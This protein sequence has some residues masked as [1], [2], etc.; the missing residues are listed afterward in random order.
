[1]NKHLRLAIFSFVVFGSIVSSAFAQA[2]Q[3][4]LSGYIS[5]TDGGRIVNARIMARNQAG[6]EQFSVQS[7]VAGN[8]SVDNL[9]AGKYRVTVEAEGFSSVSRDVVVNG[10]ANQSLDIV[11]SV[12]NISESVTVTATR[13]EL[14]TMET[15]VPVSIVGREDLER[16]NP[17]SIGDIFRNLPGTSTVNEGSFQV[18]PRI[19]GLDSNRVLI[20]VDGERLNNA[21]TS[22]ANSGVEIGLVEV[23]QIQTLEVARGAGSVL[24]GT[25]AL[26]GTVNIITKDTP[27]RNEDGFRFGT[28]FNGFASSNED[29]R[30]GSF[31]VNGS[32]RL[33]AFRVSQSLE[34]FGNYSS[35]D[36]PFIADPEVLNSQSHAGNTQ[37]TARFF[38]DDQ[39]TLK[40]AYDRRR[41]SDI[42]SPTL[43]GVFN[44]FFPFSNREK[45]STR[46]EG[47]DFNKYLARF[48]V[49][50][51]YQKQ[52]RNFTNILNVPAVL[53]FF[54][55]QFQF[56]ETVTKTNTFGFDAQSN[57]LLGERNFL[58][59]GVSFFRDSNDDERFI[60]RLT[61]NFAVFP[62]VL[63]RSEDRTKSV[64]DSSFGS[65]AAFAQDEFSV[66]N[67]LKFVGGV[68]IDFFRSKAEQTDGFSLPPSFTQSQ[69]EDLGV[70]GLTSG[71]NIHQTA[72]TGDFGA[73]FK[74]NERVSLTG[75]I[76]RSFRM[77]NL[78]ERFFTDAGSVGGFVVGNP[79][80]KAESGIN[81]DVGA[82]FQTSRF[83]GSVTYFT[84][85][86]TNFLSTVR[87][88]DRNGDP[89]RILRP[90]QSPIDVSQ[91]VNIG[92]A[93]IQGIE[94]EMDYTINFAGGFL[95]PGGSI[96]YLRGDNRET[97][98]PLDTITPL[99]T[100]LN[101][102]WQDRPN[103]YYGEWTTRI[104]NR[105]NRL[106][107]VFLASNGGPEPGFAV[108]DVRGGYN[109][110]RERYR[111]GI[112]VGITNLFD[113][114]FV[115]QFVLAPARGRSFVFG[116]TWEIF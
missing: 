46:Y 33:F 8:F 58:T 101:L 77:P 47:T 40:F 63:V 36:A 87:A 57:W 15:A 19:R 18:R 39:N 109:F 72:V 66:T 52:N 43:V 3:N 9:P 76:G 53:P 31:A 112:N 2:I 100:V 21:R 34:R 62:P 67:R 89:I 116:T 81:I 25:D 13:T 27:S 37:A 102:R 105:Q 26:G 59:T 90:G 45:F 80:L 29:G 38:L 78:F 110:R 83:A 92:K 93:R 91:T 64:P 115:E 108:S 111:L 68:R 7:D 6:V 94:A 88:F 35:G 84:N 99:K 106:S 28:A 103:R 1:M 73:V 95:T 61:P 97:D 85:T 104:V 49:S 107:T 4:N 17:N 5:D 48:S 71:L 12:G 10:T 42:G 70:Q 24:Y 65:F 11:L 44:A 86:Y 50:G 113:R 79:D 75:R 16:Q 20:L 32:S 23:G 22:T 41:A 30:R 82:K 14:T 60:E 51:Y 56:S 98:E 69:I 74:L 114:Y 55:G 54:P 96:S